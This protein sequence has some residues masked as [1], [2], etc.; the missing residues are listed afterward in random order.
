MLFMTV[1][2]M[3]TFRTGTFV[4][5]MDG[6]CD[7]TYHRVGKAIAKVQRKNPFNEYQEMTLFRMNYNGQYYII[8]SDR[9]RPAT[10]DE[11][12]G[13]PKDMH[14]WQKNISINV[15]QIHWVSRPT[16]YVPYV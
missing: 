11:K 16:S 13:D 3:S 4:M 14:Y 7:G 8:P 1:F 5:A 10:Q 9:L 2:I 6:V 12:K 15:T